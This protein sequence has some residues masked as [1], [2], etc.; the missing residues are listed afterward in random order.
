MS[1]DLLR[2]IDKIPF[3]FTMKTCEYT[4]KIAP[5]FMPNIAD[6]TV[7]C[8]ASPNSCY[9]SEERLEYHDG[10]REGLGLL[11]VNK[12]ENYIIFVSAGTNMVFPK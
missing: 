8:K 12:G 3:R 9:R 5:W 2:I 4:R 10:E 11:V 1:A 6:S 7:E